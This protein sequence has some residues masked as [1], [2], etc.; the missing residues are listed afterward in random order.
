MQFGTGRP[1]TPPKKDNL[2]SLNI[3]KIYIA[4]H[5]DDINGDKTIRIPVW[6]ISI[7]PYRKIRGYFDTVKLLFWE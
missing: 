1:L 5:N 3:N 2:C 4:L 6:N 7:V